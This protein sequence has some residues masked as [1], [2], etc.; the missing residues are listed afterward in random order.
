MQDS[1]VSVV[2]P[3]WQ[4]EHTIRAC[5]ESI[6]QQ[7]YPYLQIVLVDDGCTDKSGKLMDELATEDDLFQIFK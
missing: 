5:V 6:L 1:L 4:S 2:V 3:V 7:D